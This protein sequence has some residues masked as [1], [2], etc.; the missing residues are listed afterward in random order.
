MF[1][2]NSNQPPP[3]QTEQ[4]S[5]QQ[6][7]QTTSLAVTASK[8]SGRG[9]KVIVGFFALLLLVGG[10][11]A[12]V[13]LVQQQQIFRSRAGADC[14]G[15][16]NPSVTSPIS[17][18]EGCTVSGTLF[19]GTAP[20]GAD[21]NGDCVGYSQNGSGVTYTG[22]TTISLNPSCGQCAQV[23]FV[24]NGTSYGTAKYGGT[25][26]VKKKSCGDTCNS[27]ADCRNP[28]PAGVTVWCNPSTKI[29][30]GKFCPAGK[31]QPGANCQ[32]D[33]GRTCGQSCG[34]SVGLCGDGKSQCGFITNPDQCLAAEGNVK[35]QFCIPNNPQNGYSFARCSGIAARYLIGPNGETGTQN[36][37]QQD[38]IEACNEAVATATPSPT[39]T[40]TPIAIN[41]QCFNVRA[42][43][44]D[45]NEL[46]VNELAQLGPGD[47]VRFAAA[48]ST[49]SGNFTA[50]R[51]TINGSLRPQVTN[52]VLG[53]EL[54]GDEVAKVTARSSHEVV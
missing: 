7:D 19:Q 27:D 49:N 26:E 28:S 29:C 42:Y 46:T 54:V 8:P 13:Y 21:E 50:A 47:V 1:E 20:S 32:C 15:I 31:T 37:T 14:T 9:K 45:W 6:P 18:P 5:T 52:K 40:A 16:G 35:K 11:V 51:F 12:G 39:P 25:C 23:D 4:A 41:A 2:D 22:P 44:A 17:I 10:V 43:D 3:V 24:V 30:E 36:L 33:A 53:G 34:A 48:G 38:V